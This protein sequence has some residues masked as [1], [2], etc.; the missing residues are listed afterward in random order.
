MIPVRSKSSGKA[1]ADSLKTGGKASSFSKGVWYNF[2]ILRFLQ[3]LL[4]ILG[5]LIFTFIFLLHFSL[6]YV[7]FSVLCSKFSPPF[8]GGAS[9]GNAY[10]TGKG[11]K[12]YSTGKGGKASESNAVPTKSNV[13][14]KLELGQFLSVKFS[15]CCLF[16][17]I[18]CEYILC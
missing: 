3:K 7:I 5:T 9:N 12:A 6:S 8:Q 2:M 14:L 17:A 11:G 10:S 16:C 4:I 18:F 15:K 13:E 1:A